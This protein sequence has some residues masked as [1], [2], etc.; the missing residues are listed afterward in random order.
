MSWKLLSRGDMWVYYQEKG[1]GMSAMTLEVP[2]TQCLKTHQEPLFYHVIQTVTYPGCY[3]T[4]LGYL[5]LGEREE[6][7]NW[8]QYN[9]NIFYILILLNSEIYRGHPNFFPCLQPL[10]I[11][12]LTWAK[13]IQR[14][15]ITWE[16]NGRRPAQVE[17]ESESGRIWRREGRQEQTRDQPL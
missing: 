10:N 9:V 5:I 16:G 6:S 14:E 8:N 3:K 13:I 2:S 12:I 17:W 7:L 4:L 11:L 15:R 1:Q